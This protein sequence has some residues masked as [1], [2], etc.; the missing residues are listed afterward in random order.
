ML[1]NPEDIGTNSPRTHKPP[2]KQLASKSYEADKFLQ[3]C[4]VCVL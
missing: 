1:A 2:K 3:E 4:I